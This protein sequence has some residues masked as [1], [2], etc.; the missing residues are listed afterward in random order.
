MMRSI[1]DSLQGSWFFER[2]LENFSG[3]LLG[4]LRGTACFNPQSPDILHYQEEGTW[5]DALDAKLLNKKIK[6]SKEYLY[7][8]QTESNTIEKHFSESGI[9]KGLFCSLNFESSGPEEQ[10]LYCNGQDSSAT[11]TVLVA[12]AEHLCS[13]DLYKATQR[14][15]CDP[16]NCVWRIDL[17]YEVRGPQKGYI[18][19]TVFCRQ[20]SYG[21]ATINISS[22]VP[23]VST[24]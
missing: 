1:F 7:C 12:H 22:A 21:I 17:E 5:I 23:A 2:R 4:S 16:Q 14:Y 15:Y 8:Y 18:T 10:S 24:R 3:T 11:E 6:M 19:K 20:C 13:R 9:D